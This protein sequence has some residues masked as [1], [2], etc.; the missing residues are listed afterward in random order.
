LSADRLLT[1]QVGNHLRVALVELALA[2]L[3]SNYE[4]I[5]GAVVHGLTASV[6]RA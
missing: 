1:N 3:L 6:R 2:R 4:A 5:F